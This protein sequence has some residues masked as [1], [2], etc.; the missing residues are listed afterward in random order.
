L[1]TKTLK[2]NYKNTTTLI[3]DLGGVIINLDLDRTFLEISAFMGVEPFE[4][5]HA[6]VRHPFLREYELGKIN[7]TQF[8][9]EFRKMLGADLQDKHLDELWISMLRD[10]PNERVKWI[11]DLKKHF[12][13]VLLSNTNELHIEETNRKL[14]GKSPASLNELFDRVYYSFEMHERK[15]DREVFEYVLDDLKKTPEECVL[16]DDASDNIDT[17]ASLGMGY[18]HVPHNDL[19]LSMLPNGE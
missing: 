13:V 10:I 6:Y 12:E 11:L 18:V 14:T 15:P 7:T 4:L 8:R 3:F 5:R 1:S 19:T 9:V 17:A 16:F 2:L